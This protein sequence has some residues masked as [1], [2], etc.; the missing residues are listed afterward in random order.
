MSG[1]RWW[2]GRGGE[3]GWWEGRGEEGMKVEGEEG[4]VSSHSRCLVCAG[5]QM[6]VCSGEESDALQ[7]DGSA[8]HPMVKP[9][10]ARKKYQWNHG[11]E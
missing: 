10:E 11:S 6:L 5:V 1:E 8:P 4:S 9:K 2:K 3:E 7:P